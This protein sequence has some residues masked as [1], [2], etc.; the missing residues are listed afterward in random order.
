MWYKPALFL[1]NPYLLLLLPSSISHLSRAFNVYLHHFY[2]TLFLLFPPHSSIHL[3]SK[4]K[5]MFDVV[6]WVVP[7]LLYESMLLVHICHG[8]PYTVYVCVYMSPDQ[9]S[10][11]LL[12]YLAFT[13]ATGAE[14]VVL[15]I[16]LIQL[17]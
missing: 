8:A 11:D 6:D 14:E 1:N 16:Q 17:R 12:I 5:M 15:I 13:W 3:F 2:K 4:E 9:F 7:R 10:R